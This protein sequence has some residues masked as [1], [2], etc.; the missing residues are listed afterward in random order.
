MVDSFRVRLTGLWKAPD[1]SGSLSGRLNQ[2]ARLLIIPN[3]EKAS[4]KDPDFVLYICPAR[5]D[6]EQPQAPTP[7]LQEALL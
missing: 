3:L 1:G 5:E 6:G 2:T 4:P 7:W